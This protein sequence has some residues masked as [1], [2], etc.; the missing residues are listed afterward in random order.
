MLRR[1]SKLMQRVDGFSCRTVFRC[2]LR[3]L[4]RAPNVTCWRTVSLRVRSVLR[5]VIDRL[6]SELIS[7]ETTCRSRNEAA[8][9]CS[10]SCMVHVWD[11]E[12]S[13]YVAA[14]AQV[15]TF[16]IALVAAVFAWRQVREARKTRE[17]QSQPFV[18]VD[19]VPGKLW[20]NRLTLV[21]ENIGST[22]ARDVKL[23]FNPPLSSSFDD[24]ALAKSVL[25][26]EG[27]SVLPPGRRIETLFDYSHDRLERKLPMRY[28]VIVDF[29]DHRGKAEESLPYVL[30]MEY[31]YDLEF[32]SEKTLHNVADS[33]DKIRRQMEGWRSLRGR[34]LEVW[35]RDSE[36]DM[37]DEQWQHALTGMRRSVA[38]PRL[39][40]WAKLPGRS[41]LIRTIFI[42][43]R[44]WQRDRKSPES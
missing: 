31:L 12:T 22:L 26:R 44:E 21:V 33:L 41:T 14:L 25:I 39:R 10:M 2:L 30:D 42:T 28:E 24:N 5:R 3:C 34:G 9:S 40:E 23:T 20:P 17:A 36:R 19:V 11:S 15:G 4:C 18:V 32:E 16:V 1:Q 27:I 6:D 37:A 35:T 13:A 7:T 38:H 43:Y 8:A 29:T